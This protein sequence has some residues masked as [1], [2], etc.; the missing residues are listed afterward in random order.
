MLKNY[1]VISLR[2]LK[3]NKA[4][5]LINIL[6]LSTGIAC[7]VLITLY[8]Q[9][10]M[11]YEKGFSEREK[12]FR[13][14]TTFIKDGNVDTG[15]RTSPSIAFGLAEAVSGIETATR[16]FRIP[17]VDQ[18][19][20]RYKDKTFFEDN[21]MLV[22][23]TFLQIFDYKLVHGDAATVLNSPSSLMI[24]QK[25]STKIFGDENPVDESLIVNSGT[26]A[27][28]FR[29]TGVV[30]TP[31]FPSH[32]DAD[33]YMSM[34]S[35]GWG[36]WVLSQTTWTNNNMCIAFL[37]LTHP[38]NASAIE[39]KFPALM[40]QHGGAELKQS[41]RQ[42]ILKLQPL[43]KIR[44]YSA[45]WNLKSENGSGITY[46]YI[47]GSIGF[48]IL[49]L[50]CINFMNLTTAKSAQRAG[51]VGIRK[52]MGAYRGNLIRQF[53]G[54]AGVI[55]FFSMLIAF[56]LVVLALPV[57]NTMMEKSLALTSDNLPFILTATVVICVVTAV[58]AG[59]YPAF[60]LS[61]LRPTQVLKGKTLSGDGSQWLRKSL[62]VVQFVITITLL[63]GIVIIQQQLEYI[64]T[65]S[66]GFNSDQVIMVPLRTQ[67][68]AAEYASLK[69]AFSQ[70]PGVTNV[71]ATTSIPSTP[72]FRD[73]NIFKHGSSNDMSLR[74]EIVSVDEDYFKVLD[75]PILQGRDFLVGQDNL[76]ED[77]VNFPK[78]IV[79]EASLRA[80]DISAKDAIGTTLHFQPGDEVYSYNVIGVIRDFHQFSLHRDISPMMFILPSSRDNFP[81]L[82][83]TVNLASFKTVF[84]KMKQ[85]WNARIND[86]PFESVFLNE[87]IKTMYAEESRTSML[88]TLS[89]SI[90]LIISCL[91]L[92]GLSVYVAER[93]TKE[94]GIRKVVGASIRSILV[95]LSRE[96]VKLVAISFLIS[97]PIGYYLMEK[98]LENF[99]YKISP[100]VSV[101][102]VSGIVSFLVAWLTISFESFRAATK[103]PV[104]TLRNS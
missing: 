39:G 24:S 96:Y 82:A 101:F 78:V 95:M 22:D 69:E 83:A 81:Y 64:R 17:G 74:H 10:E 5:S 47:I 75:I 26:S 8:I 25:L 56:S 88:L 53:L 63:S 97:I 36:Q 70:I 33:L 45:D 6:G 80:L 35:N 93:K 72:L 85:Q 68:A 54:E 44:L 48:V 58:L 79:N 92:Y 71:S 67:Q 16:V 77:T 27:D 4:F 73:W 65:K 20:V 76:A 7:C 15:P 18:H 52:S 91:G 59:S 38:E 87:N 98:W 61:S 49:L 43:D 41:G 103:N 104:D 90:A 42:K 84:E 21:A 66:L 30:A 94:I 51:E 9:D 34:N 62:V 28:T 3:K 99:A 1:L 32:L 12:V 19:I 55:V 60:F 50:A 86:T 37:K 11:N 89:T 31:K 2:L 23:S 14:N 102:L 57:F 13:V 100:G 46:L 40:E 29:I